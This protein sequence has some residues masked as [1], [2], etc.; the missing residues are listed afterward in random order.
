MS[1]RA[2]T[3]AGAGTMFVVK[4]GSPVR[5]CRG[6]RGGYAGGRTVAPRARRRTRAPATAEAAFAS[7]P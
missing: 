2:E 4:D 1:D 5:V 6:G 7:G 3:S